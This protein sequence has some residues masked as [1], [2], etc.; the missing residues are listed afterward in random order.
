MPKFRYGRADSSQPTHAKQSLLNAENSLLSLQNN[1]DTQKQV[2]RNL[3]N[4][5]PSENMAAE[6]GAIPPVACQRC[7]LG[8]T[9]YRF[10]QPPRPARRRIPPA[11]VATIGQRAKT[12]LVSV[13]YFRRK[14]EYVFR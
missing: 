12:Q 2:L 11:S 6:S 8:R 9:D 10:G 1:L 7:E 14:F 13:D 5:K 4:L 3:L